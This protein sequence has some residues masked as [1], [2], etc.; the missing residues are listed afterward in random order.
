MKDGFTGR[1]IGKLFGHG[2]RGWWDS[3][4]VSGPH[5]I[6][7]SKDSWTMWYY[8]HDVAFDPMVQL[9]TGRVGVARSKDGINWERVRGPLTL[10]SVFEPVHPNEDRFDNAHV[11]ISDV[12]R[13]NGLFW[14]WYVGGDQTTVEFPGPSGKPTLYKGLIMRPGCALS[15]DGLHWT[16]LRGPYRGAFLEPGSPG[17]WD[18][19][20]CGWPQVICEPDD[21]FKMYYHTYDPRTDTFIVGLAVSSDGFQWQKV[22]PVLAAGKPGAFDDSGVSCRHVI[23]VSGEYLMFYEGRNSKGHYSIGLALSK[24]G[25]KWE[26]DQHGKQAGGPVFSPTLGSGRWD[27]AV[28]GT[29]FVLQVMGG[30]Y[31]LYYVGCS[32]R[33]YMSKR[34]IL[35]IGMAVS[36]GADYRVWHRWN[37]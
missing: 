23:K 21:S 12:Y 18:A 10:G 20:S 3:Y 7:D 6:Q 29:P 28:V 37:E 34:P 2:P 24:D 16:R 17:E 26:K 11:G 30:G 4:Q 1:E 33:T 25:L 36:D 32:E 13:K 15:R 9:P 14:M 8:G 22:G 31:R 5:V 35:G 19:M 27:S